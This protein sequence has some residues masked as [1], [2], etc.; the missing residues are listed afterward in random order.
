[1]VFDWPEQRV[2]KL[3]AEI[4]AVWAFCDGILAVPVHSWPE[5]F[6]M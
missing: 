4:L 6:V 3:R 5:P 2:D 1:M